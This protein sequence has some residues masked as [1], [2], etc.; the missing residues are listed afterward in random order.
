VSSPSLSLPLPRTPRAAAFGQIVRNEARLV[1]RQPTNMI[2]SI[3][4]PVVL[5]FFAGLWLPRALMSTVLL[6]I[7]NYTPLGAAVE[8]I[9]NSIRTGFPPAAPLLVLAGST[10]VLAFLARRFFRWE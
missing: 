8:A 7:S 4:L 10:L 5:L 1:R 2:G 3:A 9:Q 6:D